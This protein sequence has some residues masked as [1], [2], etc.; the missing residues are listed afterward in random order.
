M[1]ERNSGFGDFLTGILVGGAIGYVFAMLNAPRPGDET[2]Q[3][4]TERGRELRDQA[5]DTVQATVDKTGKLVSESRERL[6]TTVESTKNRVQTRVSDLKGRG[7]EVVTVAREKASDNL[8]KA[9]DSVEP[10]STPMR[11]VDPEI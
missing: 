9:A 2:R 8:R 10:S 4:L 6:G 11:P 3:I 1:G 5:M 7:E